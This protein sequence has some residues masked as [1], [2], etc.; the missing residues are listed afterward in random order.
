VS[1]DPR[2]W[3]VSD[4]LHGLAMLGILIGAV[5]HNVAMFHWY[6]EDA[7]ISFGF[8]DNIAAGYGA[9]VQPGLE[10]LEGYSDPTW[11]AILTLLSAL[12]LDLMATVHWVQLVLCLLTVPA[13]YF[14]AREVFGKRSE[15][16]L[17]V[18]AFLAAN[19]QFAIWG[20]AGLENGLWNLLFTL[21]FW[22]TA[23][24]LRDEEPGRRF[25]WSAALWLLVALT[26]PE[27]ILYAA[28]AG[29]VHLWWHLVERRTLVA[30]LQWLAVFFVPWGAYQ[31]LHFRYFAWPFPNTYYAKMSLKDADPWDWNKRPWN[32]TRSFFLEID[33]KSTR[34]NSSHRLTSRMPSSA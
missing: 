12:G 29:F 26:R 5:S 21:G 32:W 15:V 9:V 11:V 4:R 20:Q 2:T 27:G 13:A 24:E 28:V 23:R 33:R 7:A 8:A 6:I 25:P 22:R 14:A 19:S 30:S 1:I 18:P 34:L 10:R 31:A 17:L 3:S 16:P